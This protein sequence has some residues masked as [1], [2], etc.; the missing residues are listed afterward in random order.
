MEE[1]RRHRRY[2]PIL[3]VL[4]SFDKGVKS[5]A[6]RVRDISEGGVSF[7]SAEKLPKNTDVDL[8]IV[9]GKYDKVI[10]V[11]AKVGWT[12][13]LPSLNGHKTQYIIGMIFNEEVA[14]LG[15]I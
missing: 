3:E 11:K 8:E 14:E 2:S 9:S 7:Y 1:K 4:Y 6:K 13:E 12:E 10:G 5:R 15:S